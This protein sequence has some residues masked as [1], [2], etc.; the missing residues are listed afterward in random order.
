MPIRE[1]LKRWRKGSNGKIFIKWKNCN[2]PFSVI[3]GLNHIQLLEKCILSKRH[4]HLYNSQKH[5][6]TPV[7]HFNKNHI[8]TAISQDQSES[9]TQMPLRLIKVL[10]YR[11][12]GCRLFF[13]I[14]NWFVFCSFC[15]HFVIQTRDSSLVFVRTYDEWSS[16]LDGWM[17][18]GWNSTIN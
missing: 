18:E 9:D 13:V 10:N 16:W 8:V 11:F 2:F 3:F 7:Y 5:I 4:H 17:D 14:E 1:G 12:F 6:T 15:S